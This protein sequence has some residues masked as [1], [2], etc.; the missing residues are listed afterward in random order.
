MPE[1]YEPDVW[2]S[3]IRPI[4]DLRQGPLYASLNPILAVSLRGTEAG[5]PLFEPAAKLTIDLAGRLATG[6]EAYAAMGPLD[7]LGSEREGRW[8]AVV[9]L[10][11]SWWDLNLGA[12]YGWGTGDHVI[13]KM[14]L[15]IH[16]GE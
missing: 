5:H 8:Y 4:I 16:P 13:A 9:D 7:A 10:A 12:G 14:I 6:V 3:E 1:R 2:G 15:G 11:G